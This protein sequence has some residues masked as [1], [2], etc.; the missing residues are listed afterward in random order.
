MKKNALLFVFLLML[1]NI[2]FCQSTELSFKGGVLQDGRKLKPNEVRTIMANDS[3][4]LRTYNNGKVLGIFSYVIAWPSAFMLG[5]N[6]GSRIVSG[7]QNN[8]V[9]GISVAGV[10]IGLG[11]ACAADGII[12]KSVRIYNSNLHN[13]IF[14]DRIEFGLTTRG[15]IGFTM[16]F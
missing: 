12:R 8:L 3:E 15:G 1:S 10:I 7:Q 13:S 6:L 16:R 5:W 9:L 4:A 2:T 11:I 14:I